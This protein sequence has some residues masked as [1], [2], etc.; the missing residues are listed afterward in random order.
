[1]QHGSEDSQKAVMDKCNLAEPHHGETWSAMAKAIT[2]WRRK[3][4]DLLP[5]VA[6]AMPAIENL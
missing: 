4:K 2:N 1:M 3:T 5:L 6:D